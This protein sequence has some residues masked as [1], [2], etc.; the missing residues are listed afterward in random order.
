MHALA[1]V[2]ASNIS[3]LLQ[4]LPTISPSFRFVIRSD[5]EVQEAEIIRVVCHGA[6]LGCDMDKLAIAY[7][8]CCSYTA[9]SDI[10]L[11]INENRLEMNST[12]LILGMTRACIICGLFVLDQLNGNI[13]H[14]NC[15]IPEDGSLALNYVQYISWN[16]GMHCGSSIN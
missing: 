12:M 4:T 3:K 16:N 6:I 10:E 1:A 9:F 2:R 7:A 14:E 13:A 8:C 5:K 15:K 11:A